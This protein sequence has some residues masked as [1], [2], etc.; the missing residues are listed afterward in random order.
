MKK[1]QFFL[2]IFVLF[3]C[4]VQRVDAGVVSFPVETTIYLS[5]S[6]INLKVEANSSIDLMTVQSN[7]ITVTV[8]NPDSFII[9]SDD[10]YALT[11]NSNRTI[12][13]CENTNSKLTIRPS[14]GSQTVVITP[15]TQTC[16]QSNSTTNSSSAPVCGSMP[17]GIKVPWLYGAIPQDGN[18]ILLY[19]T[20]ADN[21]VNAYV[22]E[23]GTK[24]G[25][26]P[27]GVQHMGVNSRSQMTFLVQMLAQNTTYYFKVRGRNGCAVGPW[28]NEIS[29]T[30]KQLVSYNQLDIINSQLQ[31]IP[32]ETVGT[33]GYEVKVKVVDRNK[34][35]IVGASVTIHSSPQ[36]AITDKNGIADFQ[37]V[38]SGTHKISILYSGYAG[39]QSVNLTGNIKEFDV[40]VIVA[41]KAVSIS[42]F[43]FWMIGIMSVVIM[44]LVIILLKM[45]KRSIDKNPIHTKQ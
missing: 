19:F 3:F 8:S 21:P 15:L 7:S 45:N 41:K 26:Y 25:E 13:V 9:R 36:T 29:A 1:Y 24:F 27:Y 2:I 10:R 42:P 43:L 31:T 34:T 38:E 23:Y 12:Y 35:I 37:H 20:P 22:L 33:G 17:P 32:T 18:S 11:N 16:I 40:N 14:S 6:D 30:T 4:G 39:E 5:G 28:S 44:V